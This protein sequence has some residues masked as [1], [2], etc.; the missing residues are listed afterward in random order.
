MS[1]A[2]LGLNSTEIHYNSSLLSHTL[3]PLFIAE[4]FWGWSELPKSVH[5]SVCIHN[6][7]NHEGSLFLDKYTEHSQATQEIKSFSVSWVCSGAMGG[8]GENPGNHPKMLLSTQLAQCEAAVTL[9][10]VCPG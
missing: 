5:S 6:L 1:M 2:C 10:R 9:P 4:S 7:C 3:T 8:T